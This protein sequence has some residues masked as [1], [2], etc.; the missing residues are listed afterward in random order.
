[1]GLDIVRNERGGLSFDKD[2]RVRKPTFDEFRELDHLRDVGEVI[3]RQP[4]RLRPK[5]IQLF[6]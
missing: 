2:K 4:D 3:Q 6:S 1:M 5:T